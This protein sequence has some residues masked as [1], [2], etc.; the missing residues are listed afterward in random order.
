MVFCG[1]CGTENP[2]GNGFCFRCGSRL[3]IVPQQQAQETTV[4]PQ[5]EMPE[6]KKA[7]ETSGTTTKVADKEATRP[8]ED[9]MRASSAPKTGASHGSGYDDFGIPSATSGKKGGISKGAIAGL[10]VIV[11]IVAAAAFFMYGGQQ[12]TEDGTTHDGYDVGEGVFTFTAKAVYKDPY[13]YSGTLSIVLNDGKMTTFDP[14]VEAEYVGTQIDS[15]GID[16]IPPTKFPDSFPFNPNGMDPPDHIKAINE[17]LENYDYTGYSKNVV[18][19]N[20]TVRAY[21]FDNGVRTLYVA[22][23]GNVYVVEYEYSGA[24]LSF[25]RD[26]WT[27]RD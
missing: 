5:S 8:S 17:Y 3:K 26:G 4:R 18:L 9:D 1:K 25:V 16:W 11:L 21:G 10:V 20:E 23:D 13:E 22:D 27:D 12:G 24:T 19:G 15:G 14:D 2:D 7:P 6:I